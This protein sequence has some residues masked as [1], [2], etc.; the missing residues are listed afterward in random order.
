MTT[1][2]DYT[3]RYTAAVNQTVVLWERLLDEYHPKRNCISIIREK[4]N[5]ILGEI[6]KLQLKK[7]ESAP[8]GFIASRLDELNL[9]AE[10][11]IHTEHELPKNLHVAIEDLER[12]IIIGRTSSDLAHRVMDWEKRFDKAGAKSRDCTPLALGKAR[13]L[14]NQLKQLDDI[15]PEDLLQ[16]RSNGMQYL[17][18]YAARC[19][20]EGA[21]VVRQLDLPKPHNRSQAPSNQDSD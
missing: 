15:S 14:L 21:A 17:D 18:T 9:Y 4:A 11:C 5:Q 13:E 7:G 19:L 3:K 6:N 8:L 1:E 10:T 20:N 12:Q 2:I 16:A